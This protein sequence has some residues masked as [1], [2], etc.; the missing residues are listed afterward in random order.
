AISGILKGDYRVK[1]ARDG[2]KALEIARSDR[3]PDLILLDVMMPGLDGYQVCQKLKG[4]NQT[5]DIPVIFLTAKSMAEDETRGF[6]IGATDYITKPFNPEIVLARVRTHLEL[7]SQRR[8]IERLLESTLPKKVIQD[9]K[10]TGESKP[11]H[12][13]CVSV[14]FSDMVGFSALATQMSA[15]QLI[16]ELSEIFAAFDEIAEAN[17]CERIKTIG[18]AYLAVCGLPERNPSH[19]QNIITAATECLR[20]LEERNSR[21]ERQWEA[22]IGIHSGPLV[23]G[24]V[25]SKKYL[26]D[27][28]GDTVNVASRV[29]T[30]SETMRISVSETTY[31]LA[32]G[33]FVFVARG[34]VDL[35][36]IGPMNLYFVKP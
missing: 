6:E 12:F 22:R 32:E 1:A 28:F 20:Y 2:L 23:G 34:A 11:E 31:R 3:P 26:Y 35:K 9:M 5:R 19:A 18:D 33:F 8:Q 4:N 14:L 10:D 16:A 27:V 30:S 21:C 17:S 13:D 7:V 36:G 15:E 29:E 24:I 25:G